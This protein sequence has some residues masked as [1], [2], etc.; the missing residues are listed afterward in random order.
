MRS[1]DRKLRQKTYKLIKAHFSFRDRPISNSTVEHP[2]VKWANTPTCLYFLCNLGSEWLFLLSRYPICGFIPTLQPIPKSLCFSPPAITRPWGEFLSLYL[3]CPL[4]PLLL[5]WS[6][7]WLFLLSLRILFPS[8]HWKPYQVKAAS[9]LSQ[10]RREVWGH[11]PIVSWMPSQHGPTDQTIKTSFFPEPGVEH[12][13]NFSIFLA[14][15]K[16]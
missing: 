10:K 5:N 15:G 11:C 9:S 6:Y 1:I 14:Q 13:V 7:I 8:P 3:S 16:N 4:L 2:R 12:K